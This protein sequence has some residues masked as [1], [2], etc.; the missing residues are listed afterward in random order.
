MGRYVQSAHGYPE[1]VS[2]TQICQFI[3]DIGIVHFRSVF[4]TNLPVFCFTVAVLCVKE[5][6]FCLN[7]VVF[8]IHVVVFN[9]NV[10]VFCKTW[11]P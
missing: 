11:Q 4:C 2:Y 7:G 3:P 9:I 6:V 10:S 1:V 8:C 5:T